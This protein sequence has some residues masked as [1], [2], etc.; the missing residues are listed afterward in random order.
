M[1][2]LLVRKLSTLN[3]PLLLR[4]RI[5][6]RAFAQSKS[7][8]RKHRPRSRTGPAEAQVLALARPTSN[9]NGGAI[10]DAKS[11]TQLGWQLHILGRK[12]A[13]Y[14]NGRAAS[15][16]R[17]SE[18]KSARARSP[19]LLQCHRRFHASARVARP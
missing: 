3:L 1:P 15:G 11:G 13:R 17:T 19:P 10:R 14:R 9:Q 8:R 18:Q 2:S 7:E 16:G 6:F 12:G 4:C 5:E